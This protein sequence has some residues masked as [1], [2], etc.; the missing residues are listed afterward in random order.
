[1]PDDIRLI[2]EHNVGEL[3]VQEGL[4]NYLDVDLVYKIGGRKLVNKIPVTNPTKHLQAILNFPDCVKHFMDNLREEIILL[5]SRGKMSFMSEIIISTHP[6]AHLVQSQAFQNQQFLYIQ[7]GIG[8]SIRN[9]LLTGWK[10]FDEPSTL[11]EYGLQT[12]IRE[13]NPLLFK[14]R[15][16]VSLCKIVNAGVMALNIKLDLPQELLEHVCIV[17]FSPVARV[18][19]HVPTAKIPFKR[20]LTVDQRAQ[21]QYY[22]DILNKWES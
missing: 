16:F 20:I 22:N 19:H 10:G 14:I 17:M 11:S 5:Q 7:M 12:L 2:K 9:S 3:F 4:L 15:S 6:N 21:A 18:Q 13:R 8:D 1:M